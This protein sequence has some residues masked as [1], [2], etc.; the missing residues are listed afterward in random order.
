MKKL[1]DFGQKIGGAKKDIWAIFKEATEDEQ[2]KMAKR[3]FSMSHQSS[4]MVSIK[5]P[6]TVTGHLLMKCL[7]VLLHAIS[8]IS[9]MADAPIIS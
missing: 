2:S 8:K 7:P 4:L 3:L 5:K 6:V 1:N 9:W